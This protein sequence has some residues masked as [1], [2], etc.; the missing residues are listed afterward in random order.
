M[1][2]SCLA[3][4]LALLLLPSVLSSSVDPSRGVD[5]R[6]DYADLERFGPWDDRNYELTIEEV[7]LLPA[8][9]DELRV[10][11][12]AFY[13]AELRGRFP[14][15][16]RS[17]PLQYPHS[18]LLAFMAAY[19]G[20]LV[21]GQFYSKA[22]FDGERW[23]VDLDRPI[24]E[25]LVDGTTRALNGDVQISSPE[26]GRESAIEI[27]PINENI[28]VAGAVIWPIGTRQEM[29]TSTDGGSSW[30]PAAPLPQGGG[31]G[32]PTIAW[33]SDGEF[34]YTATL[35]FDL[36]TLYLYRSSDNG[37]TWED[38]ANEPGGDSR[39]EVGVSGSDKEILHV[40]QAPNSPHKDN[41]YMTWDNFNQGNEMKFARSTDSGHSWTTTGFG[42]APGGVAGDISTDAAGKI[43]YLYPAF[44]NRTIQMLTS[45]NGGVTFSP[46]TS[47]AN[48]EASFSFT[49]PSQ[50]TRFVLVY[51]S[52]DTDKTNGPFSGTIYASWSDQRDNG[53]AF[54]QVA[55]S[56]NGGNTWTFTVPH[57]AD[58]APDRYHQWLEVDDAGNV[59]V[60]YYDTQDNANRTSVHL[61]HSVSADGGV[62]WSNQRLTSAASPTPGDGFD[63]GDY[64][65][66]SITMGQLIASYTD[67]R[68]GS[69]D[70]WAAGTEIAGA[71]FLLQD[72][73]P[74][75]A[76]VE[77][78][79][80]V[81]NGTPSGNH[82][83]FFSR[84]EGSTP[85]TQGA[86]AGISVALQDARLID[87]AVADNSGQATVARQ[88]PDT[89]SGTD[90]FF[91]ALDLTSCEVS[92]VTMTE[93]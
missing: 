10:A 84:A 53:R 65:G 5:P 6:V 16:L 79:W 81:V 55:Y 50:N 91:Q 42:N 39:R 82:V 30:S 71:S 63:F 93:F 78:S 24:A 88:V 4:L 77:N 57:S 17:G 21:D 73:V 36:S 7:G 22:D 31:L 87:F 34:V 75:D 48:T 18:A 86:C 92:N 27:S 80:T 37:Q 54:I 68:D 69:V 11:V 14:G 23:A 20:Y 59:H 51:V 45:T 64:N 35:A 85:V 12:P 70:V 67:N 29:F 44:S 41:V 15:M 66:L 13:R 2:I 3:L 26:G 89:A 61:Y 43:Y 8:G 58:T 60:I 56:R 1:K 52:A 47:I 28:A 40:D 62:T 76:G 83:V 74:G 33:S 19:D 25:R 38:F 46:A 72:T 32:D 49:V 9:D 90:G